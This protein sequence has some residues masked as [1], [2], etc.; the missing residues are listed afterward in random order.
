MTRFD[1]NSEIFMLK[2]GYIAFIK[3]CILIKKVL[4]L[5]Q[6]IQKLFIKKQY[7]NEIDF[8]QN[9][10]EIGNINMGAWILSKAIKRNALK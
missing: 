1:R 7:E 9:I 5:L 10:R 2:S 6:I 4:H 8:L 3:N